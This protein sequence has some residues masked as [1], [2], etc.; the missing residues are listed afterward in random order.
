MSINV[1]FYEGEIL[2]LVG[3]NGA[4]KSTPIKILSGVHQP[5]KGEITVAEQPTKLN[6]P[7]RAREFG[8]R[9]IADAGSV[10]RYSR[11]EPFDSRKVVHEDG[12]G[13]VLAVW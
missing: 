8:I 1:A 12:Q 7:Q 6:N 13:G 2:A 10:P 5:D 11:H 4:G 9:N 3:D